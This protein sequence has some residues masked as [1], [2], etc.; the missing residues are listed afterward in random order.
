M[1]D[2]LRS[3][4]ADPAPQGLLPDAADPPPFDVVRLS[5]ITLRVTDLA[6]SRAF[7]VDAL[8][9]Q[10]THETP[11]V[12]HLRAMEDRSAF[13]LLLEEAA[14]PSAGPLSFR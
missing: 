12:L 7:Y 11:G 14:E 9:L 4:R 8:G 2:A 3:L 5:H 10:P 1:P 6:R 13:S